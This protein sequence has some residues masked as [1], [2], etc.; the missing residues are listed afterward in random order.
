MAKETQTDD[1]Q[2]GIGLQRIYIKDISFETPGTPEIFKKDWKPAVHM[3][4]HTKSKVLD[5]QVHEVTLS[6][7]V[8]AKDGENTVFIVEVNQVGIFAVQGF[9]EDQQQ[10]ILGAYCPSILYPYA[11]EVVSDL[12]TKGS[13]PQLLLAPINF[14]S[15]YLQHLERKKQ[16]G[17]EKEGAS[18][19]S[20]PN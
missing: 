20:K 1:K 5:A 13:F 15:L 8:T 6:V 17:S 10:S 19:D 3:E 2:P 4:L 9:P 14:D 16:Q 7:T 11:R 18:S 12:V